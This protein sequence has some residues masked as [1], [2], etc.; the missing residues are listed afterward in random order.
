VNKQVEATNKTIFKTLKK[1]L[2]NRK[3]DWAKYIPEV[4]WAYQ[5]T[6]RTP[7]EKTPYALAFEIKAVIPAEV[8]V[9]QIYLTHKCTNHL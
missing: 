8:G 5:I 6:K 1:K 7:T 3:G 2:S 9:V 4:L